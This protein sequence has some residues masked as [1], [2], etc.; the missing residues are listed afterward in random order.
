MR[1][2]VLALGLALFFV[3]SC[4][5]LFAHSGGTDGAGGHYNHSTGEYH[6]HHGYPAHYHLDGACPYSDGVLSWKEKKVQ[7]AIAAQEANPTPKPTATPKPTQKPTPTPQRTA[8]NYTPRPTT[9]S[10]PTNT[11]KPISAS[12]TTSNGSNSWKLYLK[13]IAGATIVIVIL[14]YICLR[15]WGTRSKNKAAAQHLQGRVSALEKQK[16]EWISNYNTLD[17]KYNALEQK[18]N[19]YEERCR[20]LAAERN[21]LEGSYNVLK[22][23]YDELDSE[24]K[25]A[26]KNH[27]YEQYAG[28]TVHFLAGMPEDTIIGEDGLPREKNAPILLRGKPY[29]GEKYTF[30]TS[31]SKH[32]IVYHKPSCHHGYISVHALDL[33]AFSPCGHCNPNLPNMDWYFEYKRIKAIKDKYDIP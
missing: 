13:V 28:R 29:W 1:Q 26:I 8:Y 4:V 20:V 19:A 7:E 18:Y 12:G 17:Q 11:S 25:Q 33:A 9:A 10:D 22:K 5:N 6:Y 21:A 14:T 31:G 32:S 16:T 3:L 30:Y 27:F 23:E 15:L 24:Y 2:R